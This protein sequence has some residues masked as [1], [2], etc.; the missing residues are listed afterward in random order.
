MNDILIWCD[1][2]DLTRQHPLDKHNQRFSRPAK[3]VFLPTR[4][5]VPAPV[6]DWKTTR[7]HCC[8]PRQLTMDAVYK[9]NIVKTMKPD[10]VGRLTRVRSCPL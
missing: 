8:L 7:G 3:C 6:A 2:Y 9:H 5:S 10:H 1:A 4:E